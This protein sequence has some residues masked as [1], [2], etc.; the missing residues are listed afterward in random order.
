MQ[1]LQFAVLGLGGGSAIG[2][3]ALGI[4]LIQKGTGTLNLAHGGLAMLGGFLYL[5]FSHE[6]GWPVGVSIAAVVFC[7]ALV[8]VAIHTLIFRQLSSASP[9]VKLVATL[10]ALMIIQSSVVMYFGTDPRIVLPIFPTKVFRVGGI[11]VPLDRLILVAIVVSLA[12]GLSVLFHRTVTGLAIL[13][14]SENPNAARALGWSTDTIGL[15]TWALGA[16]LA[17]LAGVLIVPLSGL[18]TEGLTLVLIAGLAAALVSGFNSFAV[19]AVAA[20]VIGMVQAVLPNY[21]H[22]QGVPEAVPFLVIVL[23]LMVRGTGLPRRSHVR[24]RLPELGAKATSKWGM[25]LLLVVASALV[26]FLPVDWANAIRVTLVVATMML[27]VVVLTGYAGQLSLGQYAIGGIGAFVAGRLVSGHD[28]AFPLAAALGVLAAVVFGLIFAV[29]ALRTRGVH[30]AVVTLGLG[31]VLQKVL[32]ENAKYTGHGVGTPVGETTLFGLS[33][34]AL[35]EPRRYALFATIV[36]FV[37]AYVVMN[38]RRSVAGRRLIAVRTNE[39]AAAALGVSVTG[40]KLYAF[41]VASALAGIAG[42]LIAFSNR[43]IVYDFIGPLQ[44]INIATLAVLGGAGYVSGSVFGGQLWGGGVGSELGH[45]IGIADLNQWLV[46]ITGIVLVL[47]LKQ[48]PNGM[49]SHTL[50]QLRRLRERFRPNPEADAAVVAPVDALPERVQAKELVVEAVSVS[51]GGV[52]ALVDVSVTVGPGQIVGVIGPNGSGK[53]TLIDAITGFVRPDHGSIKLAGQELRDVPAFERNRAGLSRSFQSLELFDDI[54][55]IE[56]IRVASDSKARGE[57]LTSIVA[58]RDAPLSAAARNAIS[59]FGLDATLGVR[60]S[61][62]S[63]GTRRL[64]AIA[65]AMASGP[66]VLLLD[67]PASGLSQ[68]EASEL[69][70]AVRRLAERWGVGVLVVEHNM[71]FMMGLCDHIV[72]LNFGQVI[73]AGPPAQIGRSEVV[74]S[75]YLGVAT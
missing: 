36:F 40:A 72:V 60:P 50:G 38:I 15:I 25:L 2:L 34:D 27:S 49:A 62:V 66:S 46:L 29:P 45:A 8:G 14:A 19:A 12:V 75:A 68:T 48:D 51:F 30:L 59:E 21:I 73:D 16:G 53:T 39:R 54:S 28:V 32:F 17:G 11:T 67:E 26:W 22:Q 20:L 31:L 57:Y 64:L 6:L 71:A 55:V 23:M 42:I 47:L 69:A 5:Q 18:D 13:G 7:T 52:K 70:L 74:V 4:V 41:A 1:F 33:I 44:S 3:M 58:P 63:Y 24:D 43:V 61:E 10:A 56:N 37:L 65:R 9:L 35:S